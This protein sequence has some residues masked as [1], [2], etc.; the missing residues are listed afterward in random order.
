MLAGVPAFNPEICVSRLRLESNSENLCCGLLVRTTTDLQ[1]FP[2]TREIVHRSSH[3]GEIRIAL[4]INE[5]FFVLGME[6]R[7]LCMDLQHM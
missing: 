5:R 3:Q 1:F 2:E 4:L 7:V 6:P